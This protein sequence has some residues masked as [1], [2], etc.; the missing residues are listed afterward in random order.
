M[1]CPHCG[2]QA[3]GQFVIIYQCIRDPTHIY[4]DGCGSARPKPLSYTKTKPMTLF[5]RLMTWVQLIYSLKTEDVT[6]SSESYDCPLCDSVG[7]IFRIKGSL[8]DVSSGGLDWGG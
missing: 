3:N 5:Q 6:S 1:Q 7:R 8:G 4:C 2:K